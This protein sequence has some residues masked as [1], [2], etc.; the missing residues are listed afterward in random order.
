MKGTGLDMRDSVPVAPHSACVARQHVP[1][2]DTPT[3]PVVALE[4]LEC[5]SH[6]RVPHPHVPA[7]GGYPVFTIQPTPAM[8]IQPTPAKTETYLR[9]ARIWE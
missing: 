1:L 5:C 9:V 4:G 8:S 6:L 2:A 7:Q 3:F